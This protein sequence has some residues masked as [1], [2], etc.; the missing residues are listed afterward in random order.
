MVESFSCYSIVKIKD[1]ETSK[2]HQDDYF[3]PT[4]RA[5]DFLSCLV[6]EAALHKTPENPIKNYTKGEEEQFDQFIQALTEASIAIVIQAPI[7]PSA[8]W[9]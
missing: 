2:S 8:S 1:K 5:E 7:A 9:L 6:T 4:V 3:Q